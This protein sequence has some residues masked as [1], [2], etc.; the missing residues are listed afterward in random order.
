MAMSRKATDYVQEA[1]RIAHLQDG[2]LGLHN[3]L[4]KGMR[5]CLIDIA[6]ILRRIETQRGA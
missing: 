4:Q 3:Q 1:E 6:P 5:D 2:K